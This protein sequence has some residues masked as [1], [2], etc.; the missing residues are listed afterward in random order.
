VRRLRFSFVTAWLVLIAGTACGQF[1][2]PAQPAEDR[3]EQ[4]LTQRYQVGV[5][6]RAGGAP[7][8]GLFGTVPVPK[9][10]PEQ[11][12]RIVDEQISSE[13]RRVTYRDV[14]GLRQMLFTIPQLPAATT[15][16]ALVTFEVTRKSVAP[17][18][19]PAAFVFPDNVPRDL[20]VYLA[21]SPGIDCRHKSIRDRAEEIVQGHEHVWK[22]VEAIYDWV[23]D[24][25]QYRNGAF[26]GATAALQNGS[27]NKEDL[28]SLFIALCRAHKVPARTV[29]VV[30]HLHAEFY[31]QAGNGRGYWLPCQVAGTRDFGGISDHRPILQKGDSLKVPE[32]EKAQR[33]V[34]EHLTGRGG[35]PQVEFVRRIVAN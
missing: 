15:A 33:F 9:E 18:S 34:P 1:G 14:D 30:D 35:S 7:C 26:Q 8:T 21:S 29:W 31:L 5:K 24:N 10:W 32:D 23:R 3:V 25:V 2:R 4:Q 22:Q 19:N 12:V 27:G 16:E 28:V 6:I 17:P 13:V 20:R 11:E